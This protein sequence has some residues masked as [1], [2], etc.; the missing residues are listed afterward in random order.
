[1]RRVGLGLAVLI[2]LAAPAGAQESDPHVIVVVPNGAA[3]QWTRAD[4]HSWQHATSTASAWRR[5]SPYRWTRE[6]T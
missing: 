1:M 2:G 5:V 3:T 4:E 6:G